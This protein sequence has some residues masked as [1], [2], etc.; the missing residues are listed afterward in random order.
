VIGLTSTL[1]AQYTS[2]LATSTFDALPANA[3][4]TTLTV[5]AVPWLR[6]KIA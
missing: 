2:R 3:P 1:N 6:M 4:A 5:G